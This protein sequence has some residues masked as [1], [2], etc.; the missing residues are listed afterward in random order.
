MHLFSFRTLIADDKFLGTS[1]NGYVVNELPLALV[2]NFG[3][4]FTI[5][6]ELLYLAKFDLLE[7][8]K[9]H[10]GMAFSVLLLFIIVH[11]CCY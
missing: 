5:D 11:V 2:E 8:L 10:L 4:F 6:S 1:F 7:L 3:C 9:D